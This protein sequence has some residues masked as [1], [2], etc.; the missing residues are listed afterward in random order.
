[1]TSPFLHARYPA[2]P[3]TSP[4]TPTICI[5]VMRRQ[6]HP[7]CE[8]NKFWAAD[9]DC[10]GIGRGTTLSRRISALAHTATL[11][12][13]VLQKSSAIWGTP[14]MLLT[15]SVGQPVTHT[16]HS[17][18]RSIANVMIAIFW[19]WPFVHRNIR[20]RLHDH[21]IRRAPATDRIVRGPIAFAVWPSGSMGGMWKRGHGPRDVVSIAHI[22]LR[23]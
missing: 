9:P 18:P 23:P 13:W 6:C 21:L 8:R 3:S 22:G 2:R 4:S 17:A 1:M 15:S 20:E 11:P 7:E 16:R 10:A 19:L 5:L 14:V 12:I